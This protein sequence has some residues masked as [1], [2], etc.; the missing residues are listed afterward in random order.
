MGQQ[1]YT[2]GWIACA[3][4]ALVGAL[5][6]MLAVPARTAYEVL[7]GPP[8]PTVYAPPMPPVV[9]VVAV[10]ADYEPTPHRTDCVAVAWR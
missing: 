4:G 5:V 8:G 10:A 2:F 6:G 7:P 9:H 3:L 1:D